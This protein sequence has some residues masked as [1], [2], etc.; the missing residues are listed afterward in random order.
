VSR[1]AKLVCTL[2]PATASEAG[3]RALAEAG[4]DV[5][6]VNMSHGTSSSHASSVELV[7]RIAESLGRPLAVMADLPGPKIRLGDLVSEPL[8]LTPGSPFVLRPGGAPG[9]ATGAATSYPG[10]ARDL[11]PGDRIL[12]AD[13]AAELRVER[14]DGDSVVTTVV[15]GGGVRARAGVNVPAERLRLPA[16]TEGDRTSLAAALELGVD[17]VA[18]SFVRSGED[19]TELRSLMGD[20]TVPIVAKIETRPAVDA[21][22]A[23]VRNADAV[24]VARGDLGVELPLEEIPV[25]QKTLLRSAWA[26]G[27][28]TIVATQMLES[29]IRAPR[30]TRAEASD[31]AN[32]V[33]DGADA[34][35]LSG[36][37]AVGE[38][39]IEAAR[40]AVR[41]AEVA[42]T[43]GSDF[44]AVAPVC[45]H[46]DEAAAVAHAAA[47]IAN[48]DPAVVAIA[49]YTGS[50]LTANLLSSERPRVPIVAFVADPAVRRAIVVRWGVVPVEARDPADTDEMIALMDEGL[51]SRGLVETGAPVVMAASSPAG[52]T[53][54]N[55]LKVHHVGDAAR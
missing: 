1:R 5:F 24:M 55:L 51:R 30:P 47:Q 7:R 16:I 26:A 54:T 44:R 53:H 38:F 35:M 33:L 11:R 43:R 45:T 14:I 3:V 8:L 20:R 6:R 28:A 9:D 46:Q 34:I 10:L 17:L 2:G 29:M 22:D 27:R 23:V 32:A 31:V 41:I 21:I 40:T 49:C 25:L 42:E 12:L 15:R 13:G 37:T 19:V 36:E 50:G 18:Q 52:R 48:D 4:T 39:P